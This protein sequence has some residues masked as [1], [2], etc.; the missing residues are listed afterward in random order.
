MSEIKT[1]F[2]IS[3]G[4]VLPISVKKKKLYVYIC[5]QEKQWHNSDIEEN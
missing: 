4:I 5:Q 2:H 3:L 1:H